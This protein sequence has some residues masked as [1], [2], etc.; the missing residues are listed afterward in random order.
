MRQNRVP[1]RSGGVRNSNVATRTHLLD[2]TTRVPRPLEEVFPFFANARNL[3]RITP[4]G[5]G[6]R[7]TSSHPL[8]MRRNLMIDYQ[9]RISGLPFRWRSQITEWNPPHSFVDEQLKGPYAEWVHRHEF[10]AEGGH[11]LMRDVVRYRLPFGVL[12][13]LALPLVK[14]QLRAIFDYRESA[15]RCLFSQ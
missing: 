3:E 11:T 7:I 8:E 5:M 13:N 9:L 6:F 1:G 15:I 4:P 12:G 10:L 2:R 14:R